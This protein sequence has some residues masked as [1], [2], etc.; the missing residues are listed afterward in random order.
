MLRAPP[1]GRHED[2]ECIIQILS[3]EKRDH[4]V[5]LSRAEI[6]TL[7]SEVLQECETGGANGFK[8][9]WS[10][11]VTKEYIREGERVE[12]GVDRWV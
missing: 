2:Q 3:G 9:R 7:A 6:I 11:V 1:S 8:G 5:F 10:V 4:S 12:G